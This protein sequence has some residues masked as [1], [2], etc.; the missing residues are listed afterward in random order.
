M[1]V[2]KIIIIFHLRYVCG[3][4]YGELF[5]TRLDIGIL[6]W[7]IHNNNKNINNI[8]HVHQV[9]HFKSS[10]VFEVNK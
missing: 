2:V 10:F 8:H 4:I 1:I 5:V 7:V 9:F 3:L 6:I